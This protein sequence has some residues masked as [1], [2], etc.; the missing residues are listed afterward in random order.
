[1]VKEGSME[2][3]SVTISMTRSSREVVGLSFSIS[4]QFYTIKRDAA[5][6]GLLCL[7]QPILNL[8][9][10]SHSAAP[11][12]WCVSDTFSGLQTA[13]EPHGDTS[14]C[15]VPGCA[16]SLGKNQVLQGRGANR[17]FND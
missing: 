3:P 9:C 5:A 2:R 13:T 16:D 10:Q 6:Y 11:G 14:Y 7:R 8:C 4:R 17:G 15:Y 1:M 12:R